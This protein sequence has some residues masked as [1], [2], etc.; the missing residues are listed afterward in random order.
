VVQTRG[1]MAEKI[2]RSSAAMEAKW[3]TL[4]ITHHSCVTHFDRASKLITQQVTLAFD[5]AKIIR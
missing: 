2:L 3:A 5:A 1:I 4:P